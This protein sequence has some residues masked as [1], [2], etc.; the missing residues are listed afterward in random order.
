MTRVLFIQGPL[1]GQTKDLEEAPAIYEVAEETNSTL[2]QSFRYRLSKLNYKDQ[3]Q[4]VFY[5]PADVPENKAGERD[6][7]IQEALNLL[8]R[9]H[10]LAG[11]SALA[12][13]FC[14]HNE[15]P[16]ELFHINF[17]KFGVFPNGLLTVNP[18]EA[19][20]NNGTLDHEELAKLSPEARRDRIKF[21]VADGLLRC[22]MDSMGKQI[23]AIAE[24]KFQWKQ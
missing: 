16:K 18:H 7:I 8:F 2:I 4:W 9:E 15:S 24:E 19:H 11:H 12:V 21:F 20:T 13:H 1:H 22:F 23:L 5:I 14:Q 3:K 6:L 17:I 10:M